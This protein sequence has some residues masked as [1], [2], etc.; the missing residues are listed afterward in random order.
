MKKSLFL[1]FCLL[2][3][4]S[5]G[6]AA[7]DPGVPEGIAGTVFDEAGLPLAGVQVRLY[8]DEG[9]IAT[10]FT[11]GNGEYLFVLPAGEYRLKFKLKGYKPLNVKE[12]VVEADTITVVDVALKE[13][14]KK[15]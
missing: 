5:L 1:G 15:K 8:N 12:A 3:L 2:L 10:T 6:A 4:L 11:D 7:D 14:K 13:K 9:R